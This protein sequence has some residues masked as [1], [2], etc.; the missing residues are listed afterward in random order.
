[1]SPDDLLLNVSVEAVRSWSASFRFLSD[2]IYEVDPGRW[3]YKAKN[4]AANYKC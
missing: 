1:M 4:L 3:P 2:L